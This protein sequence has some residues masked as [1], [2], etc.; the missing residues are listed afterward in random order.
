[1]LTGVVI[2][3]SLSGLFS[4]RF[5][6]AR[7][8]LLA[9]F[10]FQLDLV[11]AVRIYW[12]LKPLL[13]F[14]FFVT[15]FGFTAGDGRGEDIFR[16]G[17]IGLDT[18]HSPAFT[19]L[20]NQQPPV[21]ELGPCRVVAAY[22]YG[23]RTIKSSADRIPQYTEQL[24]ELGI[25][26]CDSIADLLQN[27]DGVL[28]ETNDGSL[29]LEQA[30]EVI[31]AGKPMFVDKPVAAQFT[32]VVAIYDLAAKADVPIFSC[33]S[34][35]YSS[36][37]QALRAG[38]HGKVLGCDAYSPCSLEPSHSDLFWYGIHGVETLF[39]VMG[40]GCRSVTRTQTPDFDVVVGRWA[41][42][43]IGTFRGIRRGKNGYGGTAFTDTTI[44][45]IGDYEGYRPLVLEIA[46]FFQTGKPPIDPAETIELYAFMT[47]AQASSEQGGIPITIADVMEQASADRPATE[48]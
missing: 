33:S 13:S 2:I 19:K 24:R 1:M 16:I 6:A 37:A 40:P 12:V 25:E 31:A 8:A 32:D 7:S 17:I 38:E 44:R 36:G 14:V 46:K 42:G 45:P 22:P 23:S 26:I 34:L 21:P 48:P 9:A 27:V 20:F 47:A 18:S 30:R 35:R 28:L 39:T 5:S 3:R 41:D 29:H 43:R 11:I 15:V 4:D 10:P